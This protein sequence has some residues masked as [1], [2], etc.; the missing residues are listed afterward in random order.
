MNN[1]SLRVKIYEVG[2]RNES[3]SWL[4]PNSESK[5][6]ASFFFIN[7]SKSKCMLDSELRIFFAYHYSYLVR[8]FNIL[9]QNRTKKM[10]LVKSNLDN[11]SSWIQVH[12][13]IKLS[14]MSQTR[15]N[16]NVSKRRNFYFFNYKKS[17]LPVWYV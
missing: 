14:W 11:N 9:S 1:W 2:W 7:F 8:L 10:N 17:F 5:K 16:E 6:L 3:C 12:F 15:M 13:K 4:F